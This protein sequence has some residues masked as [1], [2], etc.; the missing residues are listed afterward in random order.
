MRHY[1]IRGFGRTKVLYA[2][3]LTDLG[4]VYRFRHSTPSTKKNDTSNIFSLAWCLMKAFAFFLIFEQRIKVH[5]V[6]QI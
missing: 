5:C 4:Q 3:S 1:R 6:V 2:V